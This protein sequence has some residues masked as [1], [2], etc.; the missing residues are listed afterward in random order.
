MREADDARR[1]PARWRTLLDAVPA[2]VLIVAPDGTIRFA[3]TELERLTGYDRNEL[4]GRPVEV[5]VPDDQRQ[6][7]GASRASYSLSPSRRPM[8]TGLDIACRR[9]DGSVFPADVSLA[10]LEVGGEAFVVATVSDETERRRSTDELFHRAVHDPLTG[11]ANRVLLLDRLGHALA[12][13]DRRARTLA[14]LYVDLDGFKAV[15]DTWR[16]AAGD[17]VLQ[18]VAG[19]L[20][21]AVRPEDTVARFGGD[22]FVVLCED[23]TDPADAVRVADRILEDLC[24]PIQHRAGTCRLAASIGVVLADGPADG[25]ALIEAADHAMYRAKRR[26]GAAVERATNGRVSKASPPYAG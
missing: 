4:S 8:G 23:L 17:E 5:L 9:A 16:H 12:R 1:V 14:V 15:N 25:A 26:G 21:G 6:T 19:R 24:R 18:I 20:T 10:P 2:A 13:A 11:L 22:E 7:H 3:N